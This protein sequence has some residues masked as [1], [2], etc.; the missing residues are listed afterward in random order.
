MIEIEVDV[1]DIAE[2]RFTTDAVWETMASL[3]AA[4]HPHEHVIHSR[5]RS[6]L[7]TRPDFDLGLLV[8]L[9]SVG[10]WIPDLMG[11]APS[12]R[13]ADPLSQFA[14]L[15]DGDPAVAESDLRTLR[16]IAPK[17][18]VSALEPQEYVDRVSEA[19]AGYWSAVL[20]PLWERV[21]G[22]AS[23]DIAHHQ[24][25]LS[26]QGVGAT[27]SEL[28]DELSFAG[29][30]IR[31]DLHGHDIH[32]KAAGHGVW[33]VPSVFRWPW[34]AVQ[35]TVDVPVI[36]YAAR[37]A[38]LVWETSCEQEMGLASLL[39]RSRAA[40]LESLDI[41]RTTTTLAKQLSLAPGTV[42]EHLSVMTTSGLLQSR[43]DGRRVLYSRTNI[44]TLLLRGESALDRLG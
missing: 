30:T 14:A 15:R 10:R 38:G 40:I 27:I 1:D 31:V 28:H 8:E 2:T 22:I 41:P 44:G 13:P 17:S 5:L 18:R 43:R 23:A 20:E 6:L 36:C 32:A 34:I 25:T 26:S 33:F 19:L 12:A 11:P 37:G 29:R 3:N 24:N 7:P 21:E 39:G 35:A 42:S 4:I 9:S 16:Q